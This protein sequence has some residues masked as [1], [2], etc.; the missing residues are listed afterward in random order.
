MTEAPSHTGKQVFIAGRPV[1]DA[2]SE[3]DAAM[4]VAA[5]NAPPIGADTLPDPE[6]AVFL[7]PDK[8]DIANLMSGTLPR[9]PC[10]KGTPTTFARHFPASGIYQAYVH[11]SHCDVQV[12]KNARDLDEA[13]QLAI[14]T[15]SK[16]PVETAPGQIAAYL[17]GQAAKCNQSLKDIPKDSVLWTD[18][19]IAARTFRVA[20][21]NVRAG[22]WREDSANG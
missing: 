12:F 4:I 5:L 10:C 7:Q 21:D 14:A 15:W 6:A 13:R 11:C 17:E 19:R 20:A 16:R 2:Y 22:F 3:D 9:C 8:E 18:R 1:A